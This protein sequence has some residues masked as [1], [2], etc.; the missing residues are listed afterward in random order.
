ME[1]SQRVRGVPR[2]I[3]AFAIAAAFLASASSANA[4]LTISGGTTKNVSCVGGV[5]TATAATAVLNKNDLETMLASSNVQIVPGSVAT[6]IVVNTSV[7]WASG[8]GLTLDAYQSIAFDEPVTVNGTGALTIL[9]NDGGSGGDYTFGPKGKVTFLSTSND[10][11][12]NGTAFTLL[13]SMSDVQAINTSLSGNYALANFLN[14]SG[15]KNW[16]PLGTD[17]MGNVLNGSSGFTGN[18]EGLGHAITSLVVNTGAYD[19]A[20]LFGAVGGTIRDVGV[21]GGS[22]TGAKFVGGLAGLMS[23]GTVTRCYSTAK[24]GK[25]SSRNVGGLVGANYAATISDSYATGAILGS[26]PV[27]G[28][29]GVN[30]GST[31]SQSFATGSVTATVQNM[32]DSVGAGGLVGYN[33]FQAATIDNSYATGALPDSANNRGGL[34]GVNRTTSTTILNSFA[35]GLIGDGGSGVGGFVGC[36]GGEISDGYWD[37]QTSGIGASQGDG[38]VANYQGIT[39]LTTAQLQSGLP[40]GFDPTIWAENPSINGGFPYLINNPPPE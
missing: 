4:A 21:G 37:M 25:S 7:T 39:G 36:I 5:C 6:N 10:L 2:S 19:Y 15:V 11:T 1:R 34:V 14:A 38:C 30:A 16:V 28:L 32:G 17:G 40:A 9:T 13:G 23:G 20:G 24:V 12:I 26:S 35:T 31:I 8:Y 18:F 27:G 3:E 33:H 22:V 29:V